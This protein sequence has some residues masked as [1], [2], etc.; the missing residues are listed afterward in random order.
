[1]GFWQIILIINVNYGLVTV[2]DSF[3]KNNGYIKANSR[4]K[5]TKNK[6]HILTPRSSDLRGEELPL[7]VSSSSFFCYGFC[8]SVLLAWLW[9]GS[10]SG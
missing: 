4:G 1:M 7:C 8:F 5:K 2:E 9:E 10:H 3:F 6:K